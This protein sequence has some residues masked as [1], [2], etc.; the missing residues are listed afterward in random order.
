MVN[1]PNHSSTYKISSILY[2]NKIIK[3]KYVFI[4]YTI[5]L[6]KS[7]KLKAGEYNFKSGLNNKIVVNKLFKNDVFLYK[8]TIPE[9]FSNKQI[10]KKINNN[11]FILDELKK[12]YIEGDFFPDTYFYSRDT[13]RSEMLEIMNV[14]AKNIMQ[15]AFSELK[16]KSKINLSN[17]ELLIMASLVEAEAKIKEEKKKIASVFFNRIKLG[18][19]LQSDPTIIYGI[20]KSVYINRK[21]TKQDILLDHP[22]N[23][24]KING[25]PPT[26]ICNVGYDSIKA[27][28]E[29]EDTNNLYFVADG[30]GGHFFSE[31]YDKHQNYVK[32][33]K[34]NNKID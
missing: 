26:P 21:I 14:R 10:Y 23:T 28:L 18:M 6:K 5:L 1:I 34:N 17:K 30:K 31:N 2:E 7:N 20:N 8:L 3:N 9:C 24:Y 25:L 22:W 4:A 12:D 27:V 16:N 19:K 11:I 33:L 13:K 29:P 15:R 32:I